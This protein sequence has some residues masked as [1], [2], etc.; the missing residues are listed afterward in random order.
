LVNVDKHLADF[1]TN[2]S[3]TPGTETAWRHPSCN[4]MHCKRRRISHLR[5]PF[6]GA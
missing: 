4:R 2:V 6:T 5:R 1:A 3:R